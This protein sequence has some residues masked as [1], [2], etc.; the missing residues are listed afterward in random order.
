LAAG[1]ITGA[2]VGPELAIGAVQDSGTSENDLSL[3]EVAQLL[4]NTLSRVD[5][6]SRSTGTYQGGVYNETNENNPEPG[7]CGGNFTY[8][9]TVDDQTGAFNGTLTFNDFC[10]D[11][12]AISGSVSFSGT[13]NLI[14]LDLIN[15]L[16]SFNSLSVS[17]GSD[18]ITLDG[19]ISFVIDAGPPPGGTITMNVLMRD[20][21]TGKVYRFDNLIIDATDGMDVEGDFTQVSLT[22]RYFDPDYGYVDITTPTLIKI[23]WIYEWPTSGVVEIFGANG[24]FGGSTKARLTAIDNTLCRVEADVDGDG[25]YT[26]APND[27][28]SG[29]LSWINL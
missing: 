9:I 16:F 29:F 8:N 15:Y 19:T 4:E 6:N 14:S 17:E 2:T 27:Y 5:F 10:E 11:G 7:T 12:V 24:I 1:V 28:D 20:K 25:A 13:I 3:L 26:G 21:N 22:G 18:S 23:Y